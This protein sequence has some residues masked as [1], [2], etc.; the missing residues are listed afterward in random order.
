MDLRKEMAR[1]IYLCGGMSRIPGL[2]ERLE[3]ELSALFPP[4][5]RIKVNCSSFSYHSAYLGAFRF[6]QQPE[7]EKLMIT[8]D[9]WIKES[10][11]CLQ[12]WRIM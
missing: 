12:K 5:L 7:Y 4:T 1:S 3:K 9:E 11:N 10:V 2:K 6:I 8:K